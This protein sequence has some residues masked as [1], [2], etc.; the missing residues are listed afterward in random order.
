M[1]LNEYKT[2][3]GKLSV[4]ERKLRDLYLRKLALGELQGP[5]TGYA[6]IDKP[7]LKYYSEEAIMSDLPEMSAYEYLKSKSKNHFNNVALDY[8]GKKITYKEMFVEIDKYYFKLLNL[9]IKEGDIVSI[10]MPTT[11]E[12]IFLFYA[13][14]KLGAIP[15]ML[16]P[17][18]N[19]SKLEFYL[20]EN[21]SKF[22]LIYEKCYPKINKV[23]K[24]TD[25]KKIVLL[26]ISSYMPTH[27]SFFYRLKSNDK[28][29]ISNDINKN[30]FVDF[31]DYDN[32][33]EKK[34]TG[35]SFIG[36]NF[37][38]K[39]ALIVHSSGTSS[40]P[41][42]IVLSNKNI[43]ALAFQY[44]VSPLDIKKN[45]KFLSAIPA[46]AA[47]GL[48]ASVH[49]PL[50]LGLLTIVQPAV[51]R[52]N[53]SS[54][55]RKYKPNHCLTA[56]E[57]YEA[58]I[59]DT[60][61][62]D[63]SFFISPGCGGNS[64]PKE[65]EINDFF[66]SKGAASKLLKGWGMSELSSTACLETPNCKGNGNSMGVPL[67]KN[68]IAIFEPKTD[69]EK[70]IGEE[71]EI[72]VKGP[73]V[74]CNYLNNDVLTNKVK[75]KHSD[76]DVWMHSGDL[77]YID[78]DGKIYF[79]DRMERMIIRF[80]GLKICPNELESVICSHSAVAR[81]IV[82]GIKDKTYGTVPR[83]LIELKKEFVGKEQKIYSEI[84][85]ICNE[86]LTE[87]AIPYYFQF[88]SS[89]PSTAMGKPD[90]LEAEKISINSKKLYKRIGR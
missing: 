62:K 77:G 28:K 81:C 14:N 71:G 26:S 3:V 74:M 43:N 50:S 59:S 66:K 42:G 31:D 70:L 20:K 51:T 7:W 75:L 4:N 38:D 8:F 32:D 48:V 24:N 40:T 78:V 52:D 25:L 10:C 88:E 27:I 41:K 76:G 29:N 68:T 16:D 82:V 69:I 6:S 39:V 34:I 33:I 85:S 80:D 21:C 30:V 36:R 89:L 18:V 54:I 79:C 63:L 64:E 83:A 37:S 53:F 45:E 12:T 15:D 19:A 57:N 13:L 58:L 2:S 1:D 90:P 87:R 61:I 5:P 67:V 65:Q 11:P 22:L 84:L 56:P 35:C 73:N 47:F 60:K 17:R 55:V 46:F 44:E 23:Y 49:L 9:G 86:K 72:C